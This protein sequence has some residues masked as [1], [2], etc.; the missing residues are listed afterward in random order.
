MRFA[1]P[2][3]NMLK[4]LGLNS[5]QVDGSLKE[6]PTALLGGATPRHAMQTLGTEW[7]RN[8]IHPDLW[9]MAWRELYFKRLPEDHIVV[10]DVRFANEAT[11][12]TELGGYLIRVTRPLEMRTGS[13]HISETGVTQLDQD[14]TIHNSGSLI[15]LEISTIRLMEELAQR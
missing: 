12:I 7:G 10:D 5:E 15:D 3:K 11:A 4:A 8:L 2:F 1:D 14:E 6:V 9:I 13:I